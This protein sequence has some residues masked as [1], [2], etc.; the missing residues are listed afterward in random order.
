MNYLAVVP[1]SRINDTWFEKIDNGMNKEKISHPLINGLPKS[2]GDYQLEF[3][4]N[5][6]IDIVSETVFNYPYPYITEKTLRPIAC[7]RFFIVVGAA[8]VLK[9]LRSKGFDTFSDIIDDSYDSIE[10]AQ[11]RWEKVTSVIAETV[12]RP[13][14]ELKQLLK[15]NE[16]RLDK[17]LHNLINLELTEIELL[18]NV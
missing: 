2:N 8:N 18:K 14:E 13:I 11:E 15:N 6:C 7:K 12:K 1:W 16:E 3:Y 17:N 5:F 9:L 4:N 10:D